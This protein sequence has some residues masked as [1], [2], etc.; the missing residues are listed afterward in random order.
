[1]LKQFNPEDLAAVPE[2][3]IEAMIE[4]VCQGLGSR[5]FSGL[6]RVRLNEVDVSGIHRGIVRPILDN[7]GAE[8]R[9]LI[10]VTVGEKR[11]TNWADELREDLCNRG[12]HAA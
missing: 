3:D 4:H 12:L 7:A 10:L 8:A 11:G 6:N 5:S 1:M 9:R 2:V